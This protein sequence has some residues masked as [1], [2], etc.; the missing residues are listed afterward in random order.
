MRRDG[1][2]N[3]D[4]NEITL[5]SNC[6]EKN[7][8]LITSETWAKRLFVYGNTFINS[9]MLMVS[10]IDNI[11]ELRKRANALKSKKI[12][13]EVIFSYDYI[14]QLNEMF[15][16]CNR[17]SF[18]RKPSVRE[19][20]S[21]TLRGNKVKKVYDGLLYSASQMAAILACKT[22]WLLYI[23][24][25]VTLD[26]S[27]IEDWVK[28]SID[29]MLEEP[30]VLV[31]NPLWNNDFEMAQKESIREDEDFWYS[32]TFSDQ[33]YL[34]NI[35]RIKEK[36]MIF[37]ERNYLTEKKFPIYGGNCFER[38][39]SAYLNNHSL[40]RCTYKHCSYIHKEITNEELKKYN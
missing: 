3:I 20:F 26:D 29:K 17:D 22:D 30:S 35:N 7:F 4:M 2:V 37:S 1:S 23:T 14:D 27:C 38:R 5:A 12:I 18:Y 33:C 13:D 36:K 40:Y 34:I 19:F 39:F 16:G 24:E 32:N 11:D 9:R 6:F 31:C 25:D 15:E 8:R 28:K 21:A 10:N